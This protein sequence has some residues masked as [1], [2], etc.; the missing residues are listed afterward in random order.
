M[1][2]RR[3]LTA[4]QSEHGGDEVL[5]HI[6]DLLARRPRRRYRRA[7]PAQGW[8][9]SR[10]R[11]GLA[12]CGVGAATRAA[13]RRTPRSRSRARSTATSS[14]ST[15]RS[16][17]TR[18]HQGL[19]EALRGQGARVQLRLDAGDDGQAPRRH[20]YDV[21]FPSAEYA[22]RL[23]EAN[24]LL[25]STA[26][27]SRTPTWSTASSTSPGTTRAR[28][29]APY[30]MYATGLGYRADKVEGM[31]APGATWARRQRRPDFLLDDFQE[32]IGMANLVNGFQLNTTDTDAARAVAGLPDRPEA[33][34]ARHLGGHD[35]EHGQ[36]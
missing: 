35:H 2:R 9:L 10:A 31:T 1:R 33:E 28:R 18:A 30:A 6:D 16:T 26:T 14:T 4:V 7:R 8:G 25:G 24:Q 15:G 27:S 13:R 34:A 5:R 12:G 29:T 3:R 23:I 21:I 20:P 22:Q 36:R 17:S 11:G 19:R 32:A